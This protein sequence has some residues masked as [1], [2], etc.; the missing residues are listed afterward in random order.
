MVAVAATAAQ[1]VAVV[2]VA[3]ARLLCFYM[4]M[5]PVEI[6]LTVTLHPARAAA[7]AQVVLVA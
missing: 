5:A 1:A 6:L 7:A 4:P 2:P 3:V